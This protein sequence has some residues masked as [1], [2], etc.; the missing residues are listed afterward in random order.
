MTRPTS[1]VTEGW[2]L[3]GEDPRS[4]DREL[5]DRC[6]KGD[7]VAFEE[8]YRQHSTRMFRMAYRMVDSTSDAEDLLQD[9]F[10]HAHRK[11]STFRGDSSLGTWLYRLGVNRCLD[12]LRKRSARRE[13]AGGPPDDMKSEQAGRVGQVAGE[14][15]PTRID[16]ERAIKTLPEGCRAAFV[17][18]DVEGFDH[19][20]V[21][22]LLGIA[23]GTSKS[24]VHKAR[25][26]IRAWL[27][28]APEA[29]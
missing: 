16:L 10:L 20:E 7:M 11:L 1:K 3:D 21:A 24:Q 22:K 12:F 5:V 29:D 2:T 23:E 9:I 19:R 14:I 6:L 13:G 17:L 15:L 18:H 4:R 27:T 26:R 25:M 8:M 28:G